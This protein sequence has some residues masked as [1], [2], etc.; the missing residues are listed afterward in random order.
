MKDG[1]SSF[2]LGRHCPLTN[3]ECKGPE[4]SWFI[5][6]QHLEGPKLVISGGNC[7]I[8]VVASQIT[9]ALGALTQLANFSQRGVD[10]NLPKVITNGPVIR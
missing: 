7:L 3:T 1:L 9:P 6:N 4:C 10:P 5:I 2:F 8:P